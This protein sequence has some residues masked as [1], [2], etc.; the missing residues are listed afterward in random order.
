MLSVASRT[1]SSARKLCTPS[2]ALLSEDE[3][4]ARAIEDKIKHYISTLPRSS[5]NKDGSYKY[6]V[7]K[8]A[9]ED[10]DWGISR[11]SFQSYFTGQTKTLKRG[12]PRKTR[13]AVVEAAF[14][15]TQQKAG[16]N[17]PLPK[18]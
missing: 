18:V 5:F 7:I 13:P 10:H 1:R 12:R 6:G 15:L 17:C 11:K 9:W 8:A 14:N 3:W 2:D 4:A 16:M